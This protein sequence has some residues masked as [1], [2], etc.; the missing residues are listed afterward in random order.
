[1]G[2][3]V[4]VAKMVSNF[5][6]Y[7]DKSVLDAIES[8][9]CVNDNK[10]FS[11]CYE[12][13]TYLIDSL[14]NEMGDD[15]FIPA[16]KFQETYA[17]LVDKFQNMKFTI[18]GT[19]EQKTVSQLY[20]QTFPGKQFTLPTAEDVGF[21]AFSGRQVEAGVSILSSRAGSN[22]AMNYY[23]KDND[24]VRYRV[25]LNS[26][27]E[28]QNVRLGYNFENRNADGSANYSI[29]PFMEY[30]KVEFH[31]K[32]AFGAEQ[33]FNNGFEDVKPFRASVLPG[34]EIFTQSYIN[35]GVQGLSHMGNFTLGA[36]LSVGT[37]HTTTSQYDN[38]RLPY[39]P[40]KITPGPNTGATDKKSSNF[41]IQAKAGYDFL[42]TEIGENLFKAGVSVNH[43]MSLFGNKSGAQVY[44]DVSDKNYLNAL[45]LNIGTFGGSFAEASTSHAPHNLNFGKTFQLNFTLRHSF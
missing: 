40:K 11:H 43:E 2:D 5:V 29:G 18:A 16:E 12:M 14:K 9:G 7:L 20:E 30:G 10:R 21:S 33:K 15:K 17:K 27:F 35:V 24:Q 41:T 34:K 28:A 23:D 26:G 1:M 6:G 37:M 36:G 32:T 31:P 42:N 45:K 13:Q 25:N 4:N 8:C 22:L 3:K 39:D 38:V 19:N 44:L